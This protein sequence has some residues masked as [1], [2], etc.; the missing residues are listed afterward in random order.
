M[1]DFSDA[2]FFQSFVSGSL[3]KSWCEFH[4]ADADLKSA[5]FNRGFI[6]HLMAGISFYSIKPSTNTL[7]FCR[8][9]NSR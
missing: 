8:I 5:S 6:I 9:A 1:S 2:P 3:R 7:I 4:T